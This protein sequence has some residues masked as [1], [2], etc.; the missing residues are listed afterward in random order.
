MKP[1]V[2]F[3]LRASASRLLT[4]VAPALGDAYLRSNLEVI[5]GLLTAAAE[6]YDRAAHVRA[7]ENRAMR[8]IFADA[9]PFVEDA[10]LRARLDAVAAESE[11][12][13]QV[14]DLNLANDRLR[15]V[16]IEI[17]ALV[18]TRKEPWA[19]RTKQ[20]IW[21]ELRASASRRSLSFFPL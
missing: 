1:E 2:D 9:V 5:A 4:E 15:S 7:E 20:A 8:R 6:E 3:V 16:L 10:A 13:L 19:A 21:S 14:S 17:H 18:E 12:S 11:G